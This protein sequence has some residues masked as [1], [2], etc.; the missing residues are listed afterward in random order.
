LGVGK[1][2]SLHIGSSLASTW[3]FFTSIMMLV[4]Y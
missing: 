2:Y 3:Y 4:R 1:E